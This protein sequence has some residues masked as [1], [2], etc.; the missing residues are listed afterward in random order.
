M[1]CPSVKGSGLKGIKYVPKANNIS[2]QFE[3]KTIW[4]HFMFP[5][6][7]KIILT[8]CLC[9]GTSHECRTME[10]RGRYWVL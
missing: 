6:D 9:G 8:M 4:L 7:L 1:L 2:E 10:A 3:L 5:K